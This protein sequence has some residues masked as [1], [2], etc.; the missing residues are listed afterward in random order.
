[1]KKAL[2]WCRWL[3]IVPAYIL[4]PLLCVLFLDIP[5]LVLPVDTTKHMFA[6]SF[7]V[8][9]AT[10]FGATLFPACAAPKARVLVGI[11]AATLFVTMQ[12]LA[13][14]Q[15]FTSSPDLRAHLES[16]GFPL[17]LWSMLLAGHITGACIALVCIWFLSRKLSS[18]DE[19]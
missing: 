3:L 19:A 16:L 13:K 12:S 15:R 17:N 6:I 7:S 2:Y 4:G 8:L 14:Y 1:M 5:F 18:E 9:I 11:C 10:S